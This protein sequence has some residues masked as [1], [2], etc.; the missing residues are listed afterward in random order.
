MS[1]PPVTPTPPAADGRAARLGAWIE[2]VGLVG[3]AFGGALAGVALT[4]GLAAG[5]L[6]T[7]RLLLAG[8]VVAVLLGAVSDL[9]TLVSPDALTQESTGQTYYRAE[10]VLAEGEMAKISD[11]TLLPGMPV[12][13]FIETTPRT[14][15]SFLVKPLSD[16]LARAF[17]GR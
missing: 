6:H 3:A 4:L 10:I 5:A 7:L 15:A 14:V 13:A 11:Q 17:R 12:E 16:Q 9:I 1:L 2:R 8:V